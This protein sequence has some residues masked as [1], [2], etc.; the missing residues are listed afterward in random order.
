MFKNKYIFIRNLYIL[1]LVCELVSGL[2]PF[3]PGIWRISMVLVAL[4]TIV[5][6]EGKR[7]PSENIVLFFVIFN[8]IHFFVS[9]L[10]IIPNTTQIGNILC[11][12]LS[13][14]FFTCLSQKGVLDDKF[15][16]FVGVVLIIAAIYKYYHQI[17]IV[18]TRRMESEEEVEFTNNTTVTFLMLLP[19]LFLF[20]NNIQKWIT[21]GICVF[22]IIMGAKRGNILAAVV[23]IVLFIYY[24][25]HDS[26]KSFFRVVVMLLVI[27]ILSLLIYRWAVS[28]DYLMYRLEKTTE[29]NS[30]GR[31]VIY[32][33][34]WHAWYDS[35]NIFYY[36]FGFGCDGTIHHPLMNGYRAHNDWL[37]ILMDYGLLG[38]LLYLFVFLNLF[39]QSS[40]IK[41][42][43]LKLVLLSAL[44][45]WFF[46]SLYSMG[47]TERTMSL[48]MISIG[49]VLGDFKI[50]KGIT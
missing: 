37:E 43:D 20:K 18:A 16:T 34:A 44:F 25:F 39:R 15:F 24:M 17:T 42:L 10:W 41:V 6:K 4:Y 40:K 22:F 28:N 3:P 9:Y 26:R 12:L 21:L 49:K 11:A 13:L 38:I 47:F 50:E 46:K 23:P 45:I 2:F 5:F 19:M 1:L 8:M 48:L 27:T 32:R 30:S 29:G 7:L 36:I 31:D 35:N 33:N 14:S